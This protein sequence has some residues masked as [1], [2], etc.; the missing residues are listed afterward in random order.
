MFP[1]LLAAAVHPALMT[2]SADFDGDGLADKA[3]FERIDVKNAQRGD[4]IYAIVVRRAADPERKEI[5]GLTMRAEGLR[6]VPARMNADCPT[7]SDTIAASCVATDAE[8]V[9]GFLL[10][11][12]DRPPQLAYWTGDGFRLKKLTP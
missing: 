12:N 5:V 7:D 9:N 11:Q 10:L 4:K 8:T 2:L 1:L 3:T 6:F